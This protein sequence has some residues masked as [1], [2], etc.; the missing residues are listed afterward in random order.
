MAPTS[1]KEPWDVLIKISKCKWQV[2]NT[3]KLE[4]IG[5]MTFESSRSLF[6][7]YGALLKWL[8]RSV[9]QADSG[10]NIKDM[11][12]NPICITKNRNDF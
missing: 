1:W 7:K 10:D 2:G 12:S 5:G 6:R 11:G 4:G 9:S 3:N 8:K